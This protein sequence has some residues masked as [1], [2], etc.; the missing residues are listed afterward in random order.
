MATP[1]TLSVTLPPDLQEFVTEQVESGRFESPSEVLLQALRKAEERAR[2]REAALQ[3]VR[4][5][6]A[7][8]VEQAKRGELRDGETVMD[9]LMQR[10]AARDAHDS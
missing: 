4:E 10:Y 3:E 2:D 8:G 1:T 6:I 7:I 9:E 5:K